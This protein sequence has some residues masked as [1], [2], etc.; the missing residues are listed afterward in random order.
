MHIPDGYLSPTTCAVTAVIAAPVWG[1]SARHLRRTLS[2]REA[3]LLAAGAAFSF[4]VMMLNVP[5]PGGST[6]HAVGGSL[7]AIMLGPSAAV[8]ALSV[9]LLI[10]ALFFQ[11]GGVTAFGANALNMAVILPLSGWVVYRALT[12]T[13]RRQRW[14]IPQPVAAACGAY[15][16]INLAALAAA[17]ELGLQPL[18]YHTPSGAPRYCPYGL[19]QTVPAMML[20]HL[21]LAGA[22]E[23]G[24]T[25]AVVAYLLKSQ[26]HLA[27]TSAAPASV[28]LAWAWRG[29]AALL[30]ACPLG[31]LAPGG[32]FAELSA[33]DIKQRVGFVP[34]GLGRISGIWGH[35]PL[36]GYSLPGSS[37]AMWHQAAGYYLSAAV[38]VAVVVLLGCLIN[39]MIALRRG[40]PDRSN[41]ETTL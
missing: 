27:P 38:A 15:V 12:V 8:I 39:W 26:P 32:A 13:T 28:P 40:A 19:S 6:A 22:V 41:G 17:V 9:T 3:P 7:L 11:D 5:V 10:Q 33:R 31:L 35:A 4:V 16:G 23:A 2:D 24:L 37:P 29:V 34:A 18:L 14:Q 21:T 20:A 30:V 25:G 36:P 1:L